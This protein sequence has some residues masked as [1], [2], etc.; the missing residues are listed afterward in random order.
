MRSLLFAHDDR[1]TIDDAGKP[2]SYNYTRHLIDRYRYL[3]DSVTFAVRCD[4]VQPVHWYEDAT[5]VCIPEMKHGRALARFGAA[6]RAVEG[7]VASHELVV[8]RLPSLIGSWALRAA[9]QTDKPVLVEFVGCPWDALW[10][11]SLKG[12]L[13]APYFRLKNQRLMG[14]VSHAVYVTEA[15]LQERYPCPGSTLACSNVEVTLASEAA[16]ASRQRRLNRL[17]PPI[18][19]GTTANLEVPYKGH[20]LVIRALAA[21]GDDRGQFTYRLI[22]PG[23]PTRLGRLATELGVLDRLEFIGAVGREDLPAVLDGVDIYVQPSR[24]EGL[25]RALI[26]AMARG[27]VAIGARTG[28]IPELLADEWLVDSGDWRGIADLLK[29]LVHRD[30]ASAAQRNWQQ[31]SEFQLEALA[32]KRR[33]FYDRFLA[34][35]G[36]RPARGHGGQ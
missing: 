6:R 12:K 21:L 22:G 26:E 19:L 24:Q 32:A 17:T 36:L 14:R 15:F 3:A 27:C 29:G 23:D 16:L 34:D 20:D 1:I 11:H 25:P 4:E 33:A 9:W 18:V 13:A 10:N 8:A 5:I 35:H 28:G 2:I 30:L 31:A 7:L